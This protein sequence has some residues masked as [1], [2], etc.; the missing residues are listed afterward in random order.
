MVPFRYLST[1]FA[2]TRCE[3]LGSLMNLLIILTA[4]KI[5]GML[6]HKYLMILQFPCTMFLLPFLYHNIHQYLHLF[7]EF[8]TVLQSGISNI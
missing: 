7:H 5:T 3:F 4:Y 1:L 2:T 8:V 6:L